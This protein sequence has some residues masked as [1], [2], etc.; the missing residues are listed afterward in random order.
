M[1]GRGWRDK[2]GGRWKEGGG[3]REEDGG[4]REEDGGRRE[5]GGGGGRRNEEEENEGKI[6]RFF[7]SQNRSLN[8]TAAASGR[9]S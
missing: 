3:W 8:L 6:I 2:D 4:R 9:S 5:D 7:D 1:E